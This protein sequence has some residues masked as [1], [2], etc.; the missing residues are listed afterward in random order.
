MST[1]T[2]GLWT[3]IGALAMLLAAPAT[4]RCD[5]SA[6]TLYGGVFGNKEYVE[7]WEGIQGALGVHE[8]V[9]LL[10]RITGLHV[11]DSDRF[12]EGHS[13]LGEG[14]LAFHVAP[15]TTLSVLGGTYFGEI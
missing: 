10:A 2:R 7:G 9:S 3:V 14:G 4:G 15:N 6:I 13:G 1:A 5:H 8:R 11:I 12:H